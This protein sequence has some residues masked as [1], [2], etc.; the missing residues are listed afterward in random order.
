MRPFHPTLTTHTL[1]VCSLGRFGARFRQ[2]TPVDLPPSPAELMA[3]CLPASMLAFT[4][5]STAHCPRSRLDSGPSPFVHEV[6]CDAPLALSALS[7]PVNHGLLIFGKTTLLMHGRYPCRPASGQ[8]DWV[9]GWRTL[10]HY[11]DQQSSFSPPWRAYS[12]V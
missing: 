1:N 11:T 5:A 12:M 8:F 4:G 10:V 6:F 7:L 3:Q 2:P 9:L